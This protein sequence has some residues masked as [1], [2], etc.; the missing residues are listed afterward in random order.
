MIDFLN[1][2]LIY[3]ISQI[4]KNSLNNIDKITNYLAHIAI[5]Y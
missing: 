4:V 1:A 3:D 5:R 2:K